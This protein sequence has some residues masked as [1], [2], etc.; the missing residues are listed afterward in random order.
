M[1]L[2]S[3]LFPKG[4]PT[5]IQYT[6]FLSPYALLFLWD[7]AVF[8]SSGDA[9]INSV[10]LMVNIWTYGAWRNDNRRS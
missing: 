9:I 6:S 3:G 2:P 10:A 8:G 5:K 7:I 1:G 4:F